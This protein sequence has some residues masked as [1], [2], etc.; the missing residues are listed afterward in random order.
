MDVC[1]FISCGSSTTIAALL[2]RG[3]T[4]F[5]PVMPPRL[6]LI[7]HCRAQDPYVCGYGLLDSNSLSVMP[8]L[9]PSLYRTLKFHEWNKVGAM[10]NLGIRDEALCF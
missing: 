5:S 1:R 4:D 2:P 3:Q 6:R 10:I 9:S 8:V 7:R